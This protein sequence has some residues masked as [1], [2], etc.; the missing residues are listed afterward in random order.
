[1]SV[2]SHSETTDR[3]PGRCGSTFSSRRMTVVSVLGLAFGLVLLL[4]PAGKAKKESPGAE[5]QHLRRAL[6]ERS[7]TFWAVEQRQE[8]WLWRLAQ[9]H[10]VGVLDEQPGCFFVRIWGRYA[11]GDLSG[12]AQELRSIETLSKSQEPRVN[13]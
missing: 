2:L 13:Q 12:V 4:A 5:N 10:C 1:V 6:M 8:T 11:A 3:E 9:E 7:A